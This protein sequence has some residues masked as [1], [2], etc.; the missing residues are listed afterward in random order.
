MPSQFTRLVVI[1]LLLIASIWVGDS[2][3][4]GVLLTQGEPR[5]ITPRGSLTDLERQTIELFENSA[6]SV[7]Y[8]V[9]ESRRVGPFGF[10]TGQRGTGS[11]FIWDAAGHVVT[12]YHV[13]AEADRLLV[14]LN[15]QETGT[16]R[17][18]GVAPDYDL[19]VLKLGPTRTPLK[20][21][22]L[23]ES[24]DLQVGQSVFAIGNPFGLSRTL[25]TGVI[26]AL[27]RRL[28]TASNREIRGVIQTD[29]AINPGN[30]GGPLL[31]SASRLIG[32]NTAIFSETGSYAGIGFAV[33][34]DVVNRVVPEL[35]SRGRVEKPGIGIIALSEEIAARLG[36]T[37]IVVES[38]IPGSSA[39]AAGLKGLDRRAGRVGDIITH[40]NGEPVFSLAE[41]AAVLQSVGVGN[42]VELTV[43]RDGRTRTV[44]LPVMD[45]S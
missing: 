21:I 30:S 23:G 44:R 36:L 5:A 45:F 2:F 9:T 40:A 11:G 13:L 12:N 18:V 6:P 19:A 32:V 27:N 8:I 3:I 28:P 25:T 42:Q 34:V 39:E 43:S 41:L 16:A 38:V 24:A 20:P 1:W 10:S 14:R 22:P 29:A 37:G 4:R 33:P 31:D 7:V 17:L 26:S 15:D 35:I